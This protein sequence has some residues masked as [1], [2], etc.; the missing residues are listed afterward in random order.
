MRK[1]LAWIVLLPLAAAVVL[2]AVANR[3]WV[4]ISFDPF[5]AEAPAYSVA[6]PMFLPLFIAFIAG[7][8]IGGLAVWRGRLRAQMAAHRA[9]RELARLRAEKAAA[10]RALPRETF[11]AAPPLLPPH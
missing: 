5:S 9:E 3:G 10:E 8:L 2:F 1:L 7:I 6:A 11:T 4:T